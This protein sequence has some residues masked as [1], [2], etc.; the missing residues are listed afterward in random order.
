MEWFGHG[1]RLWAYWDEV[2]HLAGENAKYEFGGQRRWSGVLPDLQLKLYSS[3]PQN[4]TV[5]GD[6]AYKGR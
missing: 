3:I 6:R 2:T 1:L 5:F 4:V